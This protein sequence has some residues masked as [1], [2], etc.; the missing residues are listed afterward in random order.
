MPYRMSSAGQ[1]YCLISSICRCWLKAEFDVIV[2]T[3]D[4]NFCTAMQ[5]ILQYSC[6]FSLKLVSI[7]IPTLAKCTSPSLL[8]GAGKSLSSSCRVSSWIGFSNSHSHYVA[9]VPVAGAGTVALPEAVLPEIWGGHLADVELLARFPLF[10]EDRLLH[11]TG[12]EEC[13]LKF[14][15]SL[16]CWKTR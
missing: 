8:P 12:A 11:L 14:V 16:L 9:V 13:P 10:N 1:S 2:L 3:A 6:H 4:M 15:I 5:T 7:S